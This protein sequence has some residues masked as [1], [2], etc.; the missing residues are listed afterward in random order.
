[1]TIGTDDHWHRYMNTRDY[2]QFR[3]DTWFHVFN[4]GDN[5]ELICRDEQDYLN[6]IKRFK[7]LLG[8][9]VVIPGRIRLTEFPKNSFDIASYCF[10]PN[11]FHLLIK[12]NTEIPIGKLISRACTS[13]ARYFNKKYDRVGNLFQDTLKPKRVEDDEYLVYLSAYIHNNPQ[14]QLIYPYSSFQD[15]LGMRNGVLCNKEIILKYFGNDSERYKKFVL[16]FKEN[17]QEKIAHLLIQ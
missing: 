2:K 9:Q 17:D 14:Q 16:N 12:Q 3:P 10:M 7:L 15:I 11:H 5:K 1:M 13:Y 6:L 4:R 8:F